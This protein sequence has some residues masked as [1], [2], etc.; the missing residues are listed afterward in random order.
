MIIT[1]ERERE[2]EESC[3]DDGARNMFSHFFE[4]LKN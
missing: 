3:V 4:K 1:R 2:R